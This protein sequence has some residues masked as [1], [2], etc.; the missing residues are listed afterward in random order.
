[1]EYV[2]ILG[3]AGWVWLLWRRITALSHQ[4][5]VLEARVR[6]L[7][8]EREPLLLTT[9]LPSDD[10]PLLLDTPVP[11]AANANSPTEHTRAPP[12]L[13]WAL[14]AALGA[15]YA[16][17]ALAFAAD[18]MPLAITT[19]AIAALI[20]AAPAL[21]QD[22]RDSLSLAPNVGL[23]ISAVLLIWTWPVLAA[24]LPDRIAAPALAGVLLVALSLF[25]ILRQWAR[26]NVFVIVAGAI[27]LGVAGYMRIHTRIVAPDAHVIGWTFALA[28]ALALA[29]LS[30]G[31]PRRE[32]ALVTA[33]GALGAAALI[34]FA[35]LSPTIWA[36]PWAWALCFTGAA[37]FGACAWQTARGSAAPATDWATTCW[38]G[39]GAGLAVLGVHALPAP[40]LLPATLAALA[41]AFAYAFA[42]TNWRAL[43]Y[44]TLGAAALSVAHALGGD[45]IQINLFGASPPWAALGVIALAALLTFA[46][47]RVFRQDREDTSLG[48]EALRAGALALGLIGVYILIDAGLDFSAFAEIALG[49][50]ALIAGGHLAASRREAPAGAI[51]RWQGPV[52]VGLGL[53][54]AFA[55]CGA[56]LNPWWGDAPARIEGPVLLNPLL[57]AFAMPAILAFISAGRWFTRAPHFARFCLANAVVL[58]VMWLA[59][60]LRHAFHGAAMNTEPVSPFE[61]LA[62]VLLLAGVVLALRTSADR[63]RFATL[64]HRSY[65]RIF[66]APAATQP[67][68]PPGGRRE[69]RRGRR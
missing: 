56:T 14:G 65:E 50:L 15:L 26:A 2:V 45:F 60:E 6:G 11:E 30:P 32:R 42:R 16:W 13:P 23:P 62:Y 52:L 49:A 55:G 53:T 20:A 25:A 68:S 10:E 33:G 48:A 34:V 38:A 1:M 64:V 57:L 4:V 5:K 69:R 63:L 27:V 24:A 47:W 21:R 61:A 46:A 66:G 39:A 40:G 29:A 3:L 59:L 31:V 19:L 37:V 28:A 12:L 9:P 51:G 41:L 58:I 67:M 7:A 18:D 44:A 17:Y 35:A 43:R 22:L 54:L 8:A 36:T